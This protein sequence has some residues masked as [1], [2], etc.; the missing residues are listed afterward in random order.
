MGVKNKLKCFGQLELGTGS[1]RQLAVKF[2][3]T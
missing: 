1:Q 2:K 3:E